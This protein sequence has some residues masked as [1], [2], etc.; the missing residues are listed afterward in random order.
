MPIDVQ[1]PRW[2]FDNTS[3]P[4]QVFIVHTHT[5]R[6]VARLRYEE[7]FQEDPSVCMR[8]DGGWIAEPVEWFD[9]YDRT[10]FNVEEMTDSIGQ[11]WKRFDR[12]NH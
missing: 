8:I 12:D 4:N 5:P 3:S 1:T 6:F 7:E 11:A 10:T 9:R 2:L